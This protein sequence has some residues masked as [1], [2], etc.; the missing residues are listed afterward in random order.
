[1]QIDELRS[2]L[3]T[4]ADELEPFEGNVNTLHRRERRRR[5][6]ASSV[7]GALVVVVGAASFVIARHADAGRVH[8]AAQGSKEVPAAEI[9]HFDVIVVPA[10]ADVQRIL[11][12]SP[13]VARYARLARGVR[14]AAPDARNLLEHVLATPLCA[15]ESSDGFEVQA[16]TPGSNLQIVLAQAL[17]GHATAYDVSETVGSD[18]EIFL[19]VGAT[20]VQL[21][22]VR[23]VLSTDRKVETTRELT[24][25]DA[26]EVF[27]KDFADQPGL[28]LG[29]KPSDLPASF[30][31]NLDPGASI[32]AAAARYGALDGVDTVITRPSH[33]FV[34][35]VQLAQPV[36][37]CV[38]RE[39]PTTGLADR[40]GATDMVKNDPPILIDH[41]GAYTWQSSVVLPTAPVEVASS[42]HVDGVALI[43][44]FR[45]RVIAVPGGFSYKITWTVENYTGAPHVTL[46]AVAQKTSTLPGG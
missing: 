6:I 14:T 26:Y 11:D 30:R 34:P 37:A 5:I 35:L 17:A 22:H 18:F 3:T 16:V 28:V 2:E 42:R 8:V 20:R 36:S 24:P 19:K 10:T 46:T 32:D 25:A 1:M 43:R 13:L 27:K 21:A 23:N 45:S 9:T 38:S 7:V 29:T 40:R 44:D 12:A 31:V 39:T 15:L 33:L 4:L 41:V